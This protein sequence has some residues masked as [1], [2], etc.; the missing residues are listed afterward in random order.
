MCVCYIQQETFKNII[1]M[2]Q[3][4]TLKKVNVIQQIF[5]IVNKRGDNYNK[6]THIR[7][8]IFLQSILNCNT[9]IITWPIA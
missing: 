3:Y 5:C 7:V 8:N 9:I 2:L 4:I 6:Q 1:A